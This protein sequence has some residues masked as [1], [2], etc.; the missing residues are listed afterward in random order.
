MLPIDRRDGPGS[1]LP[2][3]RAPAPPEG[4]ADSKNDNFTGHAVT[5]ARPAQEQHRAPPGPP[6]YHHSLR[7]IV[8][9]Q[10]M[11]HGGT[12]IR[13]GAVAWGG[14]RDARD[15][16]Y[17]SCEVIE[18]A[19]A[20][21]ARDPGDLAGLLAELAA[22]RLWVPLPSRNR[23]F[24]DGAAVRLPVVGYQGADYVPAFTSVQRL[25]AWAEAVPVPV[26]RAAD[27][28]TIPHVVVPAVGLAR[29]LPAGL[30]LAINPDSPSGLPLPPE[31][32][33]YLARLSPPAIVAAAAGLPHRDV[34]MQHLE[35][36]TGTR[37]LIGHPPSEPATLLGQVRHELGALPAVSHAGRAW[38][39]VPARG[40]GLVIA[41]TLDDPGSEPARAA[42]AAALGRAVAAVPLHVP[43]P[44]DVTFPGE[45]HADPVFYGFAFP[46]AVGTPPDVTQ[47]DVTQPD[48]TP[49]DGLT[50]PD[51]IARWIARNTRPFY[52]RN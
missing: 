5:A 2:G 4:A 25:T 43:F 37:F 21:L 40:E 50:E 44:V 22:S 46:A 45:P 3:G 13:P 19:L 31:C 49:A 10:A 15:G 18:R 28:Q 14:L 9:S 32:V 20:G 36:E 11:A 29:R 23:P 47:P 24:T 41:V 35:A 12:I 51:V 38:L 34:A 48:G 52:T 42:A 33:P 6:Q 39:S 16:G 7:D 8:P 1:S 26:P 17:V 30:G 27:D